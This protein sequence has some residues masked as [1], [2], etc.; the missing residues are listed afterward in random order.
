M[1]C[2]R[3]PLCLVVIEHADLAP[4]EL[5]DPDH[6]MIGLRAGAADIP[7][8]PIGHQRIGKHP[9]YAP[10]RARHG[11]AL[12][13]I[14]TSRDLGVVPFPDMIILVGLIVEAVDTLLL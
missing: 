1:A 3:L 8:R 10:A 9:R 12:R 2:Q 5:R 7:E 13:V 11:E 6:G 4:D 14:S